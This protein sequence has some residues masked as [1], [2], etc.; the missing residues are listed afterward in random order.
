MNWVESSIILNWGSEVEH[1]RGLWL[2]GKRWKIIH[3]I[4]GT[5][6]VELGLIGPNFSSKGHFWR[7]VWTVKSLEVAKKF[8]ER[9]NLMSTSA[10]DT[11]IILIMALDFADWD[12]KMWG[13]HNQ[14]F[15]PKQV[16]EALNSLSKATGKAERFTEE[17]CTPSD[18]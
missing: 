17:E 1:L 14:G 5:Y 7:V 4:D 2:Y 3:S 13:L 9:Q 10:I 18:L 16:A 11:E 12:S 6:A 8:V 15:S